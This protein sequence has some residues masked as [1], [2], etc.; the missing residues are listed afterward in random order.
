MTIGNYG[1]RKSL[2]LGLPVR[3]TGIP[4][5]GTCQ[6]DIPV[7]TARRDYN[8]EQ[9]VVKIRDIF[10]ST[11]YWSERFTATLAALLEKIKVFLNTFLVVF[12]PLTK[13]KRH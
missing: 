6:T 7:V 13:K 8:I 5:E 2:C 1:N 3:Y 10:L 9:G 4:I 12:C 11:S